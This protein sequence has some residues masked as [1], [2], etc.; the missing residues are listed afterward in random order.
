M[1]T[2]ALSAFV[3]S[4]AYA[5]IGNAVVLM[6]LLHRKAPLRLIWSGTPFYLYGVCN[7]SSPAAGRALRAFALSTNL[8]LLLAIPSWIWLEI[9]ST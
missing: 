1:I 8:A 5:V 7:R 4:T 6:V 2:L 9:A 3:A